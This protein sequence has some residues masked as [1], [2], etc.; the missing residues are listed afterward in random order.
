LKD[1]LKVVL[2][3]SEKF[4]DSWLITRNQLLQIYSEAISSNCSDIVQMLQVSLSS[5]STR[6]YSYIYIYFFF[7]FHS[8]RYYLNKAFS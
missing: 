8:W 3:K 7:F 6:F 2:S 1:L 5:F 4:G